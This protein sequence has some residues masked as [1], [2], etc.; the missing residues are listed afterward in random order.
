VLYYALA[1]VKQ[2]TKRQKYLVTKNL[3]LRTYKTKAG[4]QYR[5]VLVEDFT[6]GTHPRNRADSSDDDVLEFSSEE[7]EEIAKGEDPDVYRGSKVVDNVGNAGDN[8][9]GFFNTNSFS[10]A[11]EEEERKKDNEEVEDDEE[12]LPLNVGELSTVEIPVGLGLLQIT[13]FRNGTTMMNQ[14]PQ[15]DNIL[16][17]VEIGRVMSQLDLMR[18]LRDKLDMLISAQ[19][20]IQRL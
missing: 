19:E 12:V 9:D 7:E 20:D 14:P 4:N 10:E 18:D 13:H 17:T 16:A 15:F 11:E 5:K 1:F 3:K 6:I 2:Y 8:V